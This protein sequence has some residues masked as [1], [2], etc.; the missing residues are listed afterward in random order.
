MENILRPNPLSSGLRSTLKDSKRF[1]IE[2]GRAL[3]DSNLKHA[4]ARA[5]LCLIK[6]ID[7]HPIENCPELVMKI[8]DDRFMEMPNPY[9]EDGVLEDNENIST[10]LWFQ[11]VLTAEWHVD[12][13]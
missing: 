13:V 7:D 5:H 11:A 2:L 3:G 1:T 12:G 4:I 10:Y 8:F 9:N 6:T